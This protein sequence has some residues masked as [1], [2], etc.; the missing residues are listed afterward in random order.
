MSHR[1]HDPFS[2][3]G[4]WRNTLTPDVPAEESA[5]D[6]PATPVDLAPDPEPLTGDAALRTTDAPPLPA[7]EPPVKAT[8]PRRA[9]RTRKGQPAGLEDALA[10]L[11]E[12]SQ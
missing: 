10:R 9:R 3:R 6:V 1:P 12:A 4:N 8:K 5:D 11:D 7:P 2:P